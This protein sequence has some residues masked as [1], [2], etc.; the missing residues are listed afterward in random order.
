MSNYIRFFN[1]NSKYV[2]F[3]IVT[4]YRKSILL[5]NINLLR[6]AFKYALSKYDFEIFASVILKD[7]LHVI[8]KIDNTRNYPEIIR[9]IKFYFSTHLNYKTQ[10]QSAK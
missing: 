4:Y 10:W 2:F 9:L 5:E 3:T 7:H 6:S 8:L 1:N